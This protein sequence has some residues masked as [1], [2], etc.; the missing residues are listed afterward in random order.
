MVRHAQVGGD[1]LRRV[2]DEIN[3]TSEKRI[4]ITDN[5][6]NTAIIDVI[7]NID[8]AG[9]TGNSCSRDSC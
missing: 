4:A 8:T 5:T 7:N 2:Y 6:S 9:I 3:P 1:I